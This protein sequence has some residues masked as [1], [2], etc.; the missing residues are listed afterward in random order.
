MIANGF[1]TTKKAVV[2][3]SEM[4]TWLIS[5]LLLYEGTRY[6]TR[7]TVTSHQW[8][9][10]QQQHDAVVDYTINKFKQNIQ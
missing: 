3:V 7:G 8:Y 5:S 6:L 4:I 2:T 9:N 1:N 10:T